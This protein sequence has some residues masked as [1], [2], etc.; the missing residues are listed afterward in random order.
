MNADALIERA[1]ERAVA[2]SEGPN[3]PPKLGAAI[4]HAVFPGGARVRPQLCLAVAHA[5]SENDDLTL[6]AGAGAAIELL[7]C[8]SL[9]HDDLP[10]F[11]AADLRRGKASVH[12]AY[13]EPLAVLAGDAL[14]VMAFE[15][16]ARECD[17]LP[18]RMCDILKILSRA[19]GARDGI[20]A[21]QAWE[22][23]PEINLSA[24]HRSK[25]GAL[26]VAAAASGAASV[27]ADQ[28]PWRALG[29]RLGEAY[30]I[31]DD[32]R[33]FVLD[34]SVLGKPSGQD[35]ANAR[36]N[37]VDSL[38]LDGALEQL[39]ALVNDA[40]DAVPEGCAGA[41]PLRALVFAQ[42]K[43]LTPKHLANAAS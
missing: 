20:V 32:I 30:Q 7:H 36:P 22:S 39:N 29:E 3:A 24:Y 9:V 14:I 33:D 10:C 8:A 41:D 23:E 13:G 37:A 27:G 26:F 42:A 21:G 11:D 1:I 34:E 5:C 40:A 12:V 28:A 6:A 25:T 35:A 4:R 43:R 18:R 19:V 31:A 15:A 16:V 2:A 17:G 38:G